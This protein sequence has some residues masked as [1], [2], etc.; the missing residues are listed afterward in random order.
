MGAG[1]STIVAPATF[2]TKVAAEMWLTDRRRG[3]DAKIVEPTKVTFGA[4]AADWLATRQVGGRPIKDRTRSHYAQILARELV[5]AFGD[6]ILSTITPAD[7]R[8]WHAGCLVDRPTMRAHCYSLLKTILAAA[9]DDELIDVNPCRV[10][11]AGT[12]KRVHPIR[13]ATLAEL[14]TIVAKMPERLRLAVICSSWLAM[15]LGEVLELRRGDVDLDTGV[16]RVRRGVVRVGGRLQVDT[17][18]SAAGAR[19]IAIPPHLI[20]V[21]RAHLIEHTRPGAGALLFPSAADPNRWLQVKALYRDHHKARAAAGRDDLRWHDLRHTGAV[22]AAATG[23]TLVELMARL[24]HTTAGAAMRYQH[25]AHDRDRVV[26]AAMSE[27]VA[28]R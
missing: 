16:V 3:V 11:G 24:G 15:R 21:F 1:G 25:A 28:Q 26:A 9:V 12:A 10:R 19:D 7:I 8:N 2:P 22:L 13:P 5:P 20:E 23:A 6:A 18:K 27:L 4:Y 14:E 17:P